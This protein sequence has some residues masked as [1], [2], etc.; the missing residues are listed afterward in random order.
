MSET[1]VIFGG[2]YPESASPS[3]PSCPPTSGETSAPPTESSHRERRRRIH[4]AG[5][6]YF[7][8]TLE[9]SEGT[10]N[11]LSIFTGS[12]KKSSQAESAVIVPPPSLPS[13]TVRRPALRNGNGSWPTTCASWPAAWRTGC[14]STAPAADWARRG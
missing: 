10:M 6:G 9:E 12:W 13:S 14:A 5:A 8:D 2:I 3:S 1:V 11:L 4:P 7:A